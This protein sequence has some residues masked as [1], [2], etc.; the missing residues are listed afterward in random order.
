[1]LTKYLEKLKAGKIFDE[2]SEK[3]NYTY[4]KYERVMESY[5]KKDGT[6]GTYKRITRID[7]HES[8]KAICKKLS[9]TGDAYLKHRTYVDNAST[10]FL[11][12][13]SAYDGKYIELDVSQNLALCPKDEG[14]SAHFSGEQF[15]FHCTIVDPVNHRYHFYLSDDTNHDGVFVDQVIRDI[16]SI[17]LKMK[18]CGFKATMHLHSIKISNLFFF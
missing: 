3:S 2:Q 15:T 6:P 18:T 12:M 11:E 1:M 10:V 14:Q 17:I 8:V 7:Y 13:K 5:T 16:I 9:E 4:D